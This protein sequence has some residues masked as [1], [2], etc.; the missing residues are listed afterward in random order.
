MM[1]Y[2]D[3]VSGWSVARHQWCA[4]AVML[5]VWMNWQSC[6]FRLK[7]YFNDNETVRKENQ[8]ES[9]EAAVDMASGAA[10]QENTVDPAKLEQFRIRLEQEQNFML[11]IVAG[12]CAAIVGAAV[13]GG[14]HG[15]NQIPDWVDGGWR[16]ISRGIRGSCFRQRPFKTL[17]RCGGHMRSGGL[18]FRKFDVDMRLF[19]PSGIDA[20]FSSHPR[21]A[22]AA[23]FLLRTA[24]S[25]FQ[26][27]GSAFL[28]HCRV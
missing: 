2:Q 16:W 17:W 19:G 12:V 10:E 20:A 25:H 4:C 28:W 11:A 3:D 21:H 27:H 24:E 22:D 7:N 6:F 14:R 1:A 9:N 23:C 15:C 13:L 5:M 8:M 18:S 26:P